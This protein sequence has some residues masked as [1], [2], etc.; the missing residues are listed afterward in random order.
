MKI[1]INAVLAHC[2]LRY[3]Q[4]FL[5]LTLELVAIFFIQIGTLKKMLF[6]S[7]L[8]PA[9]K[10]QFTEIINRRSQTKIKNRTYYFYNEMINL[11]NFT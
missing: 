7:S 9:L 8:A 1:S 11:K 6:M 4:Q 2:T 3:F 10:Q 5:Q